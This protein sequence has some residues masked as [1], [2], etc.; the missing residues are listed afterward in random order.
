MSFATAVALEE[1]ANMFSTCFN[2]DI[3]T[4]KVVNILGRNFLLCLYQTPS[5]PMWSSVY[6][7]AGEIMSACVKHVHVKYYTGNT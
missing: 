4:R 3:T 5:V 1:T 7:C 2:N 6:G